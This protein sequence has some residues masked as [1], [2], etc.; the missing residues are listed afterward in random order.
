MSLQWTGIAR[1]EV[2]EL[3]LRKLG[4]RRRSHRRLAASLIIAIDE[5]GE[6]ASLEE[7]L[8]HPAPRVGTTMEARLTMLDL[9]YEGLVRECQNKYSLSGMGG[10]LMGIAG[11]MSHV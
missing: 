6:N 11:G 10:L 9:Q 4:W 2:L 1:Q 3:A 5:V 8:A 7:I